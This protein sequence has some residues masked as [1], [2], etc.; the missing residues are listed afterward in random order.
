MDRYSKIKGHTDLRRDNLT[1]SVINSSQT[2][3]D[4]YI[5]QRNFRRSEKERINQIESTVE[6]MKGDLS[7]IKTMLSQLINN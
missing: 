7:D 4:N 1:G 6:E 2:D 5:K 3:Y